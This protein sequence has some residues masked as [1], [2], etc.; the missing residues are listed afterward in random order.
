MGTMALNDDDD[1]DGIIVAKK[2]TEIIIPEPAYLGTAN[3]VT[4]L[5]AYIDF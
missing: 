5:T 1:D 3:K 4:W 2:G